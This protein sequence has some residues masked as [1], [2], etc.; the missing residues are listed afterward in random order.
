[1]R[2]ETPTHVVTAGVLV[3]LFSDRTKALRT[4]GMLESGGAKVSTWWGITDDAVVQRIIADLPGRT[5]EDV[6]DKP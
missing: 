2:E 3:Y 1:M 4:V 5:I 6:R